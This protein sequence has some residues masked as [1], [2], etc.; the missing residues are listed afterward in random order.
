MNPILQ[1]ALASILR[2]GLTLL[3]GFL[4]KAGIWSAS[5]ATTYVTAGTLA[6]LALG[7]SLWEKEKSR[8]KVLTALTMP[9]GS[10]E[11][12]LNA[13]I[14]SSDPKPSV[15]TPPDVSPTTPPFPTKPNDQP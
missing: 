4:V 5:D 3:A 12:D 2:W 15:H 8:I 9:E 7:W 14:K 6:I 11:N 1:A 10:T 13:K